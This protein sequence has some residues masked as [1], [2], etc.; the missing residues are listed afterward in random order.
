M[1]APQVASL[2]VLLIQ[3]NNQQKQKTTLHFDFGENADGRV[4]L[5]PERSVSS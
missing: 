5:R 2:A 1:I 3:L 4:E